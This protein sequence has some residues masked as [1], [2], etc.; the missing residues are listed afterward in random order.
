MGIRLEQLMNTAKDK[1]LT[2]DNLVFCN[3]YNK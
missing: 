1:L 3:R 2:A